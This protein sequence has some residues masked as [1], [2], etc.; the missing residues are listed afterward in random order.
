LPE[1]SICA[2]AGVAALPGC[3]QKVRPLGSGG[4]PPS[5]GSANEPVWVPGKFPLTLRPEL[6]IDDQLWM[7]AQ[8]VAYSSPDGLSWTEHAKTDWGERIYQT[9]VAFQGKLWMYGGMDYATSTF[10]NDVWVSADGTTWENAGTAAWSPRGSHAMVVHD[11]RLWLF[12]GG[13]HAAADRSIDRFLNDVWVTDDGLTWTQVTAAAPWPARD[14]AAVVVLGDA[15][16]L[17]GGQGLA[18]VWKTLDGIRWTQVASEAPWQSRH[19]AARLA[20]DGRLWVFGGWTGET[21]NA[22]NDV[23]FSADGATWERQAEHAPWAE[24]A[25]ISVVFDD[26]IWIYSGKHTGADDNW[27]GDLWQMS[28]LTTQ[29]T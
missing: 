4:F 18:D 25:P 11:G 3:W 21:T 17:I 29:V 10:L 12:G 16:Y 19:G 6:A 8:T 7:T 28:A 13:D 9:V 27:G 1:G 22:L 14:Q 20:F 23:W 5:P 24:R 2:T 15:L 26:R